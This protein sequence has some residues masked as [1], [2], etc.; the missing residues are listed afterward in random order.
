MEIPV[1]NDQQP[2]GPDT[3][4]AES[5]KEDPTR[6]KIIVEPPSVY[7]PSSRLSRSM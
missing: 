2:K 7:L 3:D 6:P 5:L 1:M 4:K